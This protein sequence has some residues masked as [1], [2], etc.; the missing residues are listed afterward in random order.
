MHPAPPLLKKK[1]SLFSMDTVKGRFTMEPVARNYLRI[2]GTSLLPPHPYV[3]LLGLRFD[4]VI[5]SPVRAERFV[6]ILRWCKVTDPIKWE[7]LDSTNQI[8]SLYFFL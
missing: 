5:F 7:V 6:V 8:V 3:S 2:T 1:S 4:S